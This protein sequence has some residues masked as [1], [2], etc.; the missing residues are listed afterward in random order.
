MPMPIPRSAFI[1]RRQDRLR[2]FGRVGEPL[3]VS[4]TVIGELQDQAKPRALALLDARL[5][6]IVVD[7]QR[8]ELG[9]R[10]ARFARLRSYRSRIRPSG[11]WW[12]PRATRAFARATWRSALSRATDHT[13]TA[14]P[15]CAARW[16]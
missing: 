5:E 6:A 11:T 2:P 3:A 8:G 10:R 1:A 16:R 4:N 12:P 13:L 14:V 15:P 7:L 9:T